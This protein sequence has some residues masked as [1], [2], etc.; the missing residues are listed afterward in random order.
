[1]SW[2]TILYEEHENVAKIILN[3]PERANTQNIQMIYE[4]DEA[5]KK[6]ENDPQ[7]RVIILAGAGK[8]FSAGHDLSGGSRAA[9]FVEEMNKRYDL[10][11]DQFSTEWFY[12]RELEIYYEKC[13]AI[14]NLAKPT[15]A[16]VQG[17]A[18]A[19][20][21]MVACMCDLIV[22]ADNA[23]FS[24]PTLRMAASS[25]ELLLEPWDMN[26]LRRAK[27]LL[28]T[29]DSFSAKEALELGMINRIVPLERLEEETMR[30]ARRIAQTP[31]MAVMLTKRS[32]NKT[33]DM[34]GQSLSWD[35]HFIM[36]QLAHSTESFKKWMAQANQAAA[37]G[38]MKAYLEFRD[39]K[40]KEEGAN[41]EL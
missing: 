18:I 23:V 13:L 12:F 6:A 26:N 16:Q 28:W 14:R 8:H 5:M 9:R 30:L 29:G 20:G 22:A 19:G 24:N 38:G 17:Q 40:Y 32:I 33:Q 37:K 35:Y 4:I 1:M 39:S 3:K 10:P 31:P 7:I 21:M 34:K 36:H 11:E 25:T 15:I 27:E 41:L 2:E